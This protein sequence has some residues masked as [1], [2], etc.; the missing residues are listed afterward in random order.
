MKEI[1][2]K[3]VV[4]TEGGDYTTEIKKDEYDIFLEIRTHLGKSEHSIRLSGSEVFL[5]A[6]LYEELVSDNNVRFQKRYAL[7]RLIEYRSGEYYKPVVFE[8]P[9]Y[10]DDADKLLLEEE[11]MEERYLR[12]RL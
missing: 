1:I 4:S 10:D 9:D 5:L 8:A 11:Q 6:M 12:S 7:D 3:Q 2:Y